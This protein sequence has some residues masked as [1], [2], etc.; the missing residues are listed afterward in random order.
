MASKF[1]YIALILLVIFAVALCADKQEGKKKEAAKKAPIKKVALGKKKVINT[2]RAPKKKAPSKVQKKNEYTVP[3][4][5]T[6]YGE[7]EETGD[8]DDNNKSYAHPPSPTSSPKP[9]GE[10]EQEEYEEEKP[11]YDKPKPK[12]KPKP[13]YGHHYEPEPE[14]EYE[15]P[16]QQFN[17]NVKSQK[18]FRVCTFLAQDC[19]GDPSCFLVENSE[20]FS[21]PN[22]DSLIVDLVGRHGNFIYYPSNAGCNTIGSAVTPTI[23]LNVVEDVTCFNYNGNGMKILPL[24]FKQNNSYGK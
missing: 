3:D 24:Y 18:L 19:S 4:D 21:F 7:E 10:E 6:N 1:L 5:D 12:P 14:E 13:T 8:Y 15:H 22:G 23:T 16:K 20:C 2:K 9:Y 11:E 17:I